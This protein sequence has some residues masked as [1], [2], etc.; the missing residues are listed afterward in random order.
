LE[1]GI[2]GKPN[3]GKSTLYSAVTL[4][5]AE[6]ASYPFTTIEANRGVAY[7]K[8]KCPHDE[9]N[10]TCNPK[11][12][13]CLDG[14]RYVPVKVIDVAGLV[15]DAHKGKGLGNK[16]LDD[17][18]Q[19]E[20]LIHIVDASGS[21]DLEGNPV[22]IG[23]HDPLEDVKFLEH[24]LVDWIKNIIFKD[25]RRMSRQIELDGKKIERAMAENLT[26][27]G[28]TDAHVAL[29]LR[30]L[31]ISEK[32]TQW[33]DD[34][35]LELADKIRKYSKPMI[36]AANKCDIAPPENIEK[37]KAL[38]DYIVIPTCAEAELALMRASNANLI[39]YQLGGETFNI[40][41]QDKLNEKQIK[42][43]ETI[44]HILELHKGTG[45][46]ICVESAIF[47]LLKRIIIY[48]VEDEHKLTDHD[49]NVLPDVYL[50]PI[51]ANAK[52]LAYKV[53]TELGD[54]FIRA[55][56]ARTKRVI[57]AD[58]ELQNNDIIKIVSNI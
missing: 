51:G 36:I 42:G 19:A 34:D 3:V 18:R 9:F 41:A 33:S 45:I 55:I 22:D 39:D 4:A 30:D 26:G 31:D 1:I 21:T 14:I 52:D 54:K 29:A 24:D 47:K 2:V 25:W 37:L 49:G 44:K 23:S 40:T 27:L 15:P 32:P 48:P 12:S 5:S 35:M 57:G 50:M 7:V 13:K 56:D 6:I 20:A 17:L 8:T 58:H 46:Q 38:E 28:I 53:H 16:F 11:N 10:L 43:L